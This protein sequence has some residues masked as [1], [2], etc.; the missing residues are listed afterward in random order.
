MIAACVNAGVGDIG[1]S[2]V[3]E[4]IRKQNILA[5]EEIRWHFIGHLQ[6]NK[7]KN[8]AGNVHLIHSVDSRRLA[9][10][11]SRRGA[12]LNTAIDVL[13]EVNTSGEVSKHGVRPTEA[14][15]LVE[16]IRSLG[17][18]RVQGLMTIGPF[19]PDEEQS[20]PAFRTLRELRDRLQ[21]EGFPLPH[22]SMGMSNDY[23]VAISEGA[24]IIRV[25]TAIFGSRQTSLS[26]NA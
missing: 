12:V 5:A 17:N 18:I 7:V 3:Q 21:N 4:F 13:V 24:T 2:Y 20:R 8:V 9:E 10:E 25:G 14:R 23:R 19:L 16:F 15:Q 26:A 6:R 11:I 22:L 1:E